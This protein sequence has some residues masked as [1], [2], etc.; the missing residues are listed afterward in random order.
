MLYIICHVILKEKIQLWFTK[1]PELNQLAWEQPQIEIYVRKWGHP[2]ITIFFPSSVHVR[3]FWLIKQGIAFVLC[4]EQREEFWNPLLFSPV[5]NFEIMTLLQ[6]FYKQFIGDL[7]SDIHLIAVKKTQNKNACEKSALWLTRI[8][9]F[10]EAQ[11][12]HWKKEGN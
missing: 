1:I 7:L 10:W 2:D 3:L 9:L 11:S 8:S 5:G 12:Y 4:T 6:L